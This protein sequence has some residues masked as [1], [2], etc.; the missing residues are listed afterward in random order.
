MPHIDAGFRTDWALSVPI[1]PRQ[2]LAATAAPEPP[3]DP[4]AIR[5]RSHG[6]R[7]VPYNGCTVGPPRAHSCRLVLPRIMA[8]ASFSLVTTVASKSGIQFSST[9][10]PAVVLT[11][12]VAMLSLME[13]G[14]PWSAPR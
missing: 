9:F 7:V 11:P 1:E 6:F 14:I 5:L 12:C 13:N 3:L 2:R 8:P 4:P 10:D